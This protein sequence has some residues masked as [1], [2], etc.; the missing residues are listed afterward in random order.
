M[1][2]E[3]LRCWKNLEIGTYKNWEFE[4]RTRNLVS[5]FNQSSLLLKYIRD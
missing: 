5:S 3:T 4:L 2:D 1:L